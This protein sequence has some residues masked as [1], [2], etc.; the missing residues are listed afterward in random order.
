MWEA[1]RRTEAFRK[2]IFGAPEYRRGMMR[3]F[4]IPESEIA[5]T[6]RAAEAEDLELDPLEITTC[7]RR[8][9][10]E[11]STRYQPR[12]QAAYDRLAEF[13]AARHAHSLFSTDGATVDEQV[14]TLLADRSVAVAESCTGGLLA[15]RLTDRPGSSAWFAGGVVA[16]SNQAK[17]ELVGVDPD[18]IARLG[19]VSEEVAEALAD[20]AIERFGAGFGIGITGIAGPEGGTEDKP[21]GLVCFCV[22]SASGPRI[23]RSVQ[24]P[25]N[26]ADVRDRSTTVAMHLLR[27]LLVGAPEETG[28][29]P[30]A[31]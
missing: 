6:L 20:G 25:G 30:A 31:A 17:I 24:L 2:A 18:L 23:T 13:I 8:G 9:E 21:V 4:G 15:A 1:A 29:R 27:R 3:L 19:A 16:Y 26:R 22:A 14:T 5:G 28:R 11:V 12:D 7:L 10:I